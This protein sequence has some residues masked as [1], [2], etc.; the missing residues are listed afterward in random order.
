M[1]YAISLFFSFNAFASPIYLYFEDNI[2]D[3]K[4]YREILVKD[5]SIPEAMISVKKAS[6]C[7]KIKQK[8]EL[9]LCLK[10]NGD[11]KTVSIIKKFIKESL[12]VFR[13]L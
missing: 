7:E 4:I 13:S 2:V 8:W 11:L 3:A 9:D 6:L 5:Y 10:K 12:S 1:K